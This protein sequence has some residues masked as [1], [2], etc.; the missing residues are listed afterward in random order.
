MPWR[1]NKDHICFFFFAKK[2]F[3][4]PGAPREIKLWEGKSF[5]RICA[6]AQSA[7]HKKM[8]K[9]NYPLLVGYFLVG[10]FIGV[11]VHV[12]CES[13]NIPVLLRL[14]VAIFASEELFESPA[15]SET[16][17]RKAHIYFRIGI[18]YTQAPLLFL[19]Y[20]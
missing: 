2:L 5:S 11:A 18:F 7:V 10:V 12:L 6:R 15:S 3:F 20:A 16:D 14:V 17:A 8:L 1:R 4:S 13:C 9:Q 19:R